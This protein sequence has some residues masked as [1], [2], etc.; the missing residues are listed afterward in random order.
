[1]KEVKLKPIAKLTEMQLH[2]I[3]SL[4]MQVNTLGNAIERA[5]RKKQ[6]FMEDV[7]EAYGLSTAD[8][9]INTRTG[10]VFET[11]PKA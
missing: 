10:E 7:R 3:R 6:D 1:M 4:D 9:H 8:F 5:F 2:N 11:W